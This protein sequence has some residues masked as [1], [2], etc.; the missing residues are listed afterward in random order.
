MTATNTSPPP[1]LTRS[2]ICPYVVKLMVGGCLVLAWW[3]L[4]SVTRMLPAAKPLQRKTQTMLVSL[5]IWKFWGQFCWLD[6]W[7]KEYCWGW[8]HCPRLDWTRP[9]TVWQ[10][11]DSC[12]SQEHFLHLTRTRTESGLEEPSLMVWDGRGSPDS[13]IVTTLGHVVFFCPAFSSSKMSAR[14]SV[15]LLLVLNTS[16][17]LGLPTPKSLT[18]LTWTS[19]VDFGPRFSRMWGGWT[20]G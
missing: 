7:G 13:N 11:D 15:C 10:T 5:S 6:L 16:L 12:R 19:Y 18:A 17:E 8:S 4:I 14:N 3:S 20:S 1:H 2:L 9:P